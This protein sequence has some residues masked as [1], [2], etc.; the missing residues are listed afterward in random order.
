MLRQLWDVVKG[1]LVGVTR[2]VLGILLSLKADG[3]DDSR[4][5]VLERGVTSKVRPLLLI[6][7]FFS[8]SAN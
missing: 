5:G 2:S 6:C 1:D 4:F 3:T 7:V 8:H